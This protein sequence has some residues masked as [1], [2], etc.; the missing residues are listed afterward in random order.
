MVDYYPI[1][2]SGPEGDSAATVLFKAGL[3]SSASATALATFL[4]GDRGPQGSPGGTSDLVGTVQDIASMAIPQAFSAIRTTGRD[5]PGDGAQ[6]F[7]VRVN[8]DPGNGSGFQD[9]TGQ[10]WKLA[11]TVID[12]RMF[13][14]KGS[15]IANDQA[16]FQNAINFVAAIG[17]GTVNF[18]GVFYHNAEITGATGV[19]LVGAPSYRGI[20]SRLIRTTSGRSINVPSGVVGFSLL[21][22]WLS[23]TVS[24]TAYSAGI[25]TA[26]MDGA[27]SNC[28]FTGYN[29]EA[30][31]L[32]PGNI[33][34]RVSDV[35][36]R[37]VMQ[38]F[39]R[40]SPT[41]GLRLNGTDYYVSN[42]QFGNAQNVL[43]D[44]SNYKGRG[45]GSTT[46]DNRYNRAIW[47]EGANGW[48]YSSSGENCDDAIVISGTRNRM[49]GV[50]GDQA[51]G[52]S[53]WLTSTSA[54][55]IVFGYFAQ[56]VSLDGDGA[57]SAIVNEGA[58]NQVDMVHGDAGDRFPST[59]EVTA[60]I[61]GTT[62]TITATTYG[63]IVANMLVIAPGVTAGTKIVSG[64]GTTWTVDTTQTVAS[65]VMALQTVVNTTKRP[66]YFVDDRVSGG[67]IIARN[68]YG[69][70][71]RGPYKFSK[72][73][74]A[75]GWGSSFI[76]PPI[77]LEFT[78]A[79]ADSNGTTAL[80]AAHTVATKITNIVGGF[81]YKP[82]NLYVQTAFQVTVE[83]NEFIQ[84]NTGGDR[85]LRQ[86]G[87][88]QFLYLAGKWRMSE[89]YGPAV[90]NMGD[91]MRMDYTAGRYSYAG[92]RT[93]TKA[94]LPGW[95]SL[96]AARE[97]VTWAPDQTSFILYVSGTTPGTA[98]FQVPVA[99]VNSD[100]LDTANNTSS[101]IVY[102][103]FRNSGGTIGISAG[104]RAAG[105]ASGTG[106]VTPVAVGTAFKAAVAV[107]PGKCVTYV[108]GVAAPAFAFTGSM[109]L[110]TLYIG[111]GPDGGVTSAHLWGA[112]PNVRVIPGTMGPSELTVLTT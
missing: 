65:R 30:V 33:S 60:S 5:A 4:R 6:G 68:T 64:S 19:A 48:I 56:N 74:Q 35:H 43:G 27:I 66:A 53:L 73:T 104:A 100:T 90:A 37:S 96:A 34:N 9:V 26:G 62:L 21:N 79:V 84:T 42:V 111:Q 54:N 3:I 98:N 29:D 61:S 88:Y 76:D 81:N 57:H 92:L 71:I 15:V 103:V 80:V 28:T 72:F 101:D 25:V 110:D 11:D 59:A 75:A 20:A 91:L 105:N 78:T 102:L 46:S 55:N 24:G 77:P 93:K 58:Y 23:G 94:N 38:N 2:N 41:A 8:A 106:L 85:E 49:F 7:Y 83:N 99:L 40:T 86:G 108:N 87:W 39:K 69:P 32:A 82:V 51:W 50:R 18:R 44:G 10:W 12:V 22:S 67:T 47:I 112:L 45:W 89:L 52:R 109:N 14:A 31:W 16:A 1:F 107:T 70:S 36:A 95:S 17:G 13:G 63:E 97:Q